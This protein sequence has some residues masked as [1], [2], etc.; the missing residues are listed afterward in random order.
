MGRGIKLEKIQIQ[1]LESPEYLGSHLW[2][3]AAPHR[4]EKEKMRRPHN[5]SECEYAL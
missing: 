3:F 5:A 2:C 4:T 1:V